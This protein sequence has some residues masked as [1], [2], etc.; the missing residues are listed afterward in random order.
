MSSS[1][2]RLENWYRRNCNG[3]W[4]HTY[5]IFISNIDNPGWS[6]RVELADTSL[7]EAEFTEIKIQREDELDWII[8]KVEG[9]N[10]LG[11]GGP[12][13]LNEL[14]NVFLDWAKQHEQLAHT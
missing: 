6:L 8:C 4:E 5:G 2:E 12:S 9:C 7:Y 13:N 14:L 11:Y 3:D 1:I 10:F